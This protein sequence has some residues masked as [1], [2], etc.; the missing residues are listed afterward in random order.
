ML[1]YTSDNNNSLFPNVVGGDGISGVPVE[2]HWA[3]VLK[4][5]IGENKKYSVCPKARE[6]N[7]GFVYGSV[8]KSYMIGEKG[9]ARDAERIDRSSYGVNFWLSV[10]PDN[11]ENYSG[12]N[13][14]K[15]WQNTNA[16]DQSSVPMFLDAMWYGGAPNYDDGTESK[17]FRAPE[18]NGE[19]LGYEYDM[20]HFA[21]DR[22]RGGVNVSFMDGHVEKVKVKKLW[23]LKWHKEYD[24]NIRS[25]LNEDFWPDWVE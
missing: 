9:D 24:T 23:D 4:E 1:I 20:M 5:Y 12:N 10:L 17:A 19:W 6:V 21:M 16:D 7:S 2:E 3:N 13:A 15:N 8:D 18:H 11:T 25:T 22:H 14:E